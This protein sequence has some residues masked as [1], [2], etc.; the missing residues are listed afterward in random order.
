ML[1]EGTKSYRHN[2]IMLILKVH[3]SLSEVNIYSVRVVMG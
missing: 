2:N 3:F 1:L